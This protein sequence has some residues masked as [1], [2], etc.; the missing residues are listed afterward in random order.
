VLVSKRIDSLRASGRECSDTGR[1]RTCLVD[2]AAERVAGYTENCV[3]L[4]DWRGSLMSTLIEAPPK[5]R[6]RVEITPEDLLA[7]PDGGHFEL[8]DGQLKERHVSVLSSLVAVEIVRLLAN[9]CHGKRLGSVFESELGYQCFPW[10]PRQVRRADA[11]FIRADRMTRELLASGFATIPPDLA[12]EVISPNDG[13]E[14][15]V[16]KVEDFLRAGVKL[17]WVVSPE[18]R[19]VQV[20]RSDR[21]GTLLRPEDDLSGEDV[22]PGFRCRVESLFPVPQPREAES[23]GSQETAESA[24]HD[25]PGPTS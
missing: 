14:E 5:L 11:S 23:P 15:L 8:I 3:F 18:T 4:D 20:V 7:M 16:E 12:V 22:L 21:S 17:I 9:H 24:S 19:T 10:K 6:P 13:A 1:A 2:N 25:R